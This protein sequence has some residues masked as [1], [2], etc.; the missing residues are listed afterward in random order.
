LRRRRRIG[1]IICRKHSI[2]MHVLRVQRWLHYPELE[3]FRA[4]RLLA[5]FCDKHSQ[6]EDDRRLTHQST[7]AARHLSRHG[8]RRPGIGPIP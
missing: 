7:M 3:R 8:T 5:A 1:F 4:C 6:V 2:R